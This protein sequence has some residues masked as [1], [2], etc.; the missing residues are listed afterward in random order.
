M[1]LLLDDLKIK[2]PCKRCEEKIKCKRAE[3]I[4][5]CPQL[6]YYHGQQSILSK[7]KDIELDK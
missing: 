2:N 6:A 5:D 1:K 3:Y 7:A 4:D